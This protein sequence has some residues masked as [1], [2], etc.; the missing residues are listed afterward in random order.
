MEK[1]TCRRNADK[2][3]GMQG[4]D[5]MQKRLRATKSV[6]TRTASPGGGSRG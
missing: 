2:D 3:V 4:V 6:S 1:S 5:I